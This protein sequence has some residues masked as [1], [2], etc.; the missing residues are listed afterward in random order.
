MTTIPGARGL[1]A[2]P[3]RLR[4]FFRGDGGPSV[5]SRVAT[6]SKPILWPK[7]NVPQLQRGPDGL[8]RFS[9]DDQIVRMFILAMYVWGMVAFAGGLFVALLLVLPTLAETLIAGGWERTGGFINWLLGIPYFT[10]GR[11]RPLHTNA[12]IFAFAGN[13]VYA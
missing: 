11:I 8:D 9:Y 6:A 12:A 4:E 2:F 3:H 13:A 5:L 7:S 10:F 1:S